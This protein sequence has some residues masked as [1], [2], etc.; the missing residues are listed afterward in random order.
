MKRKKYVS[1][2]LRQWTVEAQREALADV[3]GPVEGYEDVLAPRTLKAH[4]PADLK[5]RAELLRKTG[6]R[7]GDETIYVASLGVLAWVA[8]DFMACM[9]A[10]AARNATIYALDT[11][12]SIPPTATAK[13]LAEA[14]SEFLAS[15]RRHQTT[16][17]RLAGVNASRAL[18]MEDAQKRKALIEADW[19]GTE[20]PTS[21]LLDRAGKER[22]GR[23]VPMAWATAVRLMGRRPTTEQFRKAEAKR[24]AKT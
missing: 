10:A 14:L 8:E 22:R 16:G 18:R 11:G 7:R 15:R 1:N 23:W 4:S 6:R 5:E 12:R 21:V 9:A 20:V 17:G 13:E 3:P 19:H 24:K 2:I